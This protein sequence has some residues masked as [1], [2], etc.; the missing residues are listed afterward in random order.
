LRQKQS[1]IFCTTKISKKA[2]A[3]PTDIKGNAK[4]SSDEEVLL[5]A[6]KLTNER[7][8]N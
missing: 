4:A 5:I 6:I 1:K 7:K 8:K 3:G 2:T